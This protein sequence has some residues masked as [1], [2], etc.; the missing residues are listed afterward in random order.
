M[1][2]SKTGAFD[3]ASVFKDL[4]G[5]ALDAHAEVSEQRSVAT[6]LIDFNKNQ[7]RKYI[8]AGALA[9]LT[10]SVRK[11]G[12]LEPILV[13]PVGERFE[14]IAGERRTRA[15]I[16]AGLDV[17]PA[18]VLYLDDAQTLE[19]AVIE[20]LQREDLNP[21][22]ETDAILSLLSLRLDMERQEV[23][24]IVKVLY[25][26]SRGRTGNNDIS[27]GARMR[28][29]EVFN[30]VGRFTAASFHTNR[31]PLLGLPSEL[32]EA[33]RT[34]RLHY[35]KARKLARIDDSKIRKQLLKRAIEENLSLTD[36]EELI[37]D[38][39]QRPEPR[40]N[41]SATLR[42][43][44]RSLTPS[45]I[46]RLSLEHKREVEELLRSLQML[47]TDTTE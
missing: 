31:V 39:R 32:I 28:T 2:V 15:A 43:V 17:V 45:R 41:L 27:E 22:E 1:S 18:V 4:L 40:E 5:E 42:Q 20:N 38:L 25:D 7:P 6:E 29:L 36:L 13:R 3:R 47:L 26:E 12:V 23:L 16:E 10:D 21:V 30:A 46:E 34:G 33:V 44:K 19:I 8:D 9:T 35:T 37:R 11:H 14:L 24:G